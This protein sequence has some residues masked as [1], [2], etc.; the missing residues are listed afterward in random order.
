[1]SYGPT[2]RFKRLRA[3]GMPEKTKDEKLMDGAIIIIKAC[4]AMEETSRNV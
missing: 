1:M 3:A 2:W 4:T